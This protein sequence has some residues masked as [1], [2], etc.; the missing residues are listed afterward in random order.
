MNETADIRKNCLL[1]FLHLERSWDRQDLHN[2]CRR[3]LG[4][5]T[6]KNCFTRVYFWSAPKLSGGQFNDRGPWVR[7][8]GL[9]RP[10]GATLTRLHLLLPGMEWIR[11]PGLHDHPR[12]SGPVLFVSFSP[13][14]SPQIVAIVVNYGPDKQMVKA[15][16]SCCRW[17]QKM[18]SILIRAEEYQDLDEIKFFFNQRISEQKSPWSLRAGKSRKNNSTVLSF[19]GC[20]TP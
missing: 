7:H 6:N 5:R 13:W 17:T 8:I 10:S 18:T 15:E 11:K 4:R 16:A 2:P 1:C 9:A 12:K 14:L 19:A 20:I 3:R